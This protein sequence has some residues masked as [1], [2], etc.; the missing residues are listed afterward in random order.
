M[1][2]IT[3]LPRFLLCILLSAQMVSCGLLDFDVDDELVQTATEMM[4]NYDTAY[5]VR[6]LDIDLP[7][8]KSSHALSGRVVELRLNKD[9]SFVCDGVPVERGFLRFRL[10]DIVRSFRQS[11]GQLRGITRWGMLHY[12]HP[13]PG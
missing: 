11:P 6:G 1:K 10:Q 12:R 2:T 5:A 8:A 7:A 4:L 3:K 9:G 13:C